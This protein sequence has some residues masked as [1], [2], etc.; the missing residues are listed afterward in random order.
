MRYV[1]TPPV[2]VFLLGLPVGCVL[3]WLLVGVGILP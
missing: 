1:G 2:G 3:V